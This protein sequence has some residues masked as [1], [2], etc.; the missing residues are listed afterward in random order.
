MK[1]YINNYT[2]WYVASYRYSIMLELANYLL[3]PVKSVCLLTG[4]SACCL[5]CVLAQRPNRITRTLMMLAMSLRFFSSCACLLLFFLANSILVR[6]WLASVSLSSRR[7]V[8]CCGWH[9]SSSNH[10]TC[11]TCNVCGGYLCYRLLSAPTLLLLLVMCG[12]AGLCNV[13]ETRTLLSN[14][15]IY[16]MT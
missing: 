6:S 4:I 10:R 15:H 7:V 11:C 5:L 16:M 3:S 1:Y 13:K 12:K 2:S 9:L 8:L 14:P